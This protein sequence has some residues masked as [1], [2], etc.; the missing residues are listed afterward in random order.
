VLPGR[1]TDLTGQIPDGVEIYVAQTYDTRW[2]LTVDGE[3]TGRRRSLDWATAF[4][5]DSV[6]LATLRYDAPIWRQ[7]ALLVQLAA[8]FTV[9][10]ATVRRRLSGRS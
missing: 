5:P 1:T 10:G 8:F 7:A 6:G 3:R 2:R 9:L 4:V